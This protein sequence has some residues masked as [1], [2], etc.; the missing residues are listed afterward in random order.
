MEALKNKLNTIAIL[1]SGVDD[2]SI[3]PANNQFLARRILEEDGAIIS[4]FPPG[5]RPMKHHFP[6]RN[7]IVSGIS[8]GTLIVEAK[9]KSSALITARS[10]LEQGKEIFAVPGNIFSS[11]SRE[12]NNLI[13]QGAIPTTSSIDIIET[14][15]L[16]TFN[17]YSDDNK[18]HNSIT[19]DEK[20]ILKILDTETKNINEIIFLSQL[21]VSSINNLI[22]SLELKGLIKNIDG[23]NYVLK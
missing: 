21:K 17:H 13:K 18:V 15:D 23:M 10:A 16:K 19:D 6:Q 8:L 2:G 7:R 9:E 5:T 11:S 3:Y 22:T 4:E 1:G 20:L 12:T 14:L